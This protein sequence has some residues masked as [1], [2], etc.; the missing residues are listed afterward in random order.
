MNILLLTAEKGRTGVALCITHGE[1]HRALEGDVRTDG[2]AVHVTLQEPAG[3][4]LYRAEHPCSS[5]LGADRVEGIRAILDWLAS[6]SIRVDLVAHHIPHQVERDHVLRLLPEH[7]DMLV[8]FHACK[9]AVYCVDAVSDLR[10]G[11]AQV[12]FFSVQPASPEHIA[13]AAAAAVVPAPPGCPKKMK[14]RC[15]TCRAN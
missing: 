12:A 6:R 3:Q 11:M 10:H 5:E 4:V 1:S 13:T 2:A 15:E 9:A 14:V 7:V 8:G